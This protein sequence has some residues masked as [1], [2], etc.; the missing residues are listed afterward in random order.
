MTHWRTFL[1]SEV[2]RFVDV[3]ARGDVTLKIKAVKKGKVTG[4]G[5][6]AS[7]K[8]MITF[9]GQE[10]PLAAGTAV[11]SAIG[12]LYGNDTRAWPGKLITI[13]G[14][15]NVSFGGQKIGGVRVRPIVPDE[16]KRKA[17]SNG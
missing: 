9:E 11:L 14:D 7:S 4:S 6:K 1:D 5:G 15:P 12:A 16:P 10:K 17:A 3:E 2:I 8:A 13:Y